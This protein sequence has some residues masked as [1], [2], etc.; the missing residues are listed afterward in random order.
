M[1]NVKESI[2][3]EPS[4]V[5]LSQVLKSSENYSFPSHLN[6]IAKENELLIALRIS[7]TRARFWL[8][9]CSSK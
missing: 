9:V 2:D 8:I 3:D 1:F 6:G 4:F 7:A 5:D